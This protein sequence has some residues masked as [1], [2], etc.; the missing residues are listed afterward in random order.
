MPLGPLGRVR[1]VVKATLHGSARA[2]RGQRVAH[3]LKVEALAH[4]LGRVPALLGVSPRRSAAPGA[5]PG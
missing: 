1:D 2:T 3:V 4:G 5:N